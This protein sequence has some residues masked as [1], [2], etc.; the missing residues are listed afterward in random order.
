M[1]MPAGI[2]MSIMTLI[3]DSTEVLM[4]RLFLSVHA[5]DSTGIALT[6]RVIVKA[7][8]RFLKSRAVS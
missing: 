8:S 2:E 5:S 7:G 1:P 4:T 3:T 6:P